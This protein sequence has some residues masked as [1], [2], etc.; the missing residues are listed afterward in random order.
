MKSISYYI[1]LLV[2]KLKGIKKI[3]S[4]APIDYKK[5]RKED[6]HNPKSKIFRNENHKP[7]TLLDTTITPLSKNSD[8]LVLYLH[9]G[10]FV[11]GPG[12]HHWD[13][14][15]KIFTLSPCDVWM[16]DYP[17]APE[18][19]IIEIS[20][21]IDAVYQHLISDFNYK[22]IILMGDSAGA[23]LIIALVQRLI[24]KKE[25]IPNK[26][27]LISP[28]MDA[29]LSNPAI[30]NKEIKDAMLSIKGVKSAK[31]M[32]AKNLPL[33]HP[34]LS[35]LYGTFKG[36][37]E[38]HLFI[39]EHDI[40]SPDQ[41]LFAK[42]L[43]DMNIKC[44]TYYGKKMPHI[45]VLLPFLSEAKSDFG[46]ILNILIPTKPTPFIPTETES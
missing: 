5:L 11:S 17:K 28:V 22:K 3:F 23:T 40:T 4:T 26:L 12:Q 30:P 25:R 45:W 6:V 39:A 38:T 21:N 33:T 9:G 44:H 18:H 41:E 13:A 36:F 31:E 37:P 27:I 32:C 29:S 24:E 8:T 10:A 1:V 14:L 34:Y 15:A 46:S 19:D 16:C 43:N 42:K 7:F 35:P 2:L 20:T